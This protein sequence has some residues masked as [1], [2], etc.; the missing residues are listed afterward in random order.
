MRIAA[1]SIAILVL[2]LSS[3]A[4]AEIVL[5]DNVYPD[6]DAAI[7]GEY[8][9]GLDAQSRQSLISNVPDDEYSGDLGSAYQLAGLPFNVRDCREAGLI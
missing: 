5:G 8:C 1:A 9:R 2:T 3:A 6:R 7:L 4:Q